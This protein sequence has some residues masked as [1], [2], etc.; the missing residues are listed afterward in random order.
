MKSAMPM[1]LYYVIPWEVVCI[2]SGCNDQKCS[3]NT[4]LMATQ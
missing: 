4:Y 1:R 2:S 3:S